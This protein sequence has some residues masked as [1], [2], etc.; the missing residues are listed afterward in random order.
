MIFQPPVFALVLS[1]GL[2]AVMTTWAGVFALSLLR[3]WDLASGA[4]RQLELERR[5][6]LVSTVIA[7][8]LAM[9]GVS[10]ALFVFQADRTAPL[11]VG[12]MCAFGVFNASVYGFPALFM[13]IAL[14]FGA[15]LWLAMH[16]ADIRARD[17]PLIR[18]KY[19]WLLALVPLA[20]LDAELTVSF[21]MDL[22]ADTLTSCCGST[23]TPDKP[24]L[25][26]EAAAL[27]PA[28]ALWA[29]F[30]GLAITVM[31]AALAARVTILAIGY[32]AISLAFFALALVAVVSAVSIYVYEHPH[33]HCP[34]CLLKAEYGY[35]GF[36]L[37]APLFVGAAAGL[38]S[39]V[40]SARMPPSLRATL[41]RFT[42][43][44]RQVSIGGFL[45]FGALCAL[46]VWRS[47]LRV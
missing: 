18:R 29:M 19:L 5:T 35:F 1:A 14:F 26:A 13:K 22:K 12:A 31:A 44:L 25:S 43:R 20:L 10:L 39:G 4:R 36:A 33:H 46:V 21:F 6:Y 11:L 2:G 28:T 17:Y 16:H 45:V 15:S 47:G 24:G 7:L 30:I 38:A 3:H 23:F 32:G 27:A 41:P 42:A 9:Q 37:Y 34:F 8:L 40:L